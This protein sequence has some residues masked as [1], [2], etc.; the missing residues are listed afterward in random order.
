[1]FKI[2]NLKMCLLYF[3][4]LGLFLPACSYMESRNFYSAYKQSNCEEARK[5]LLNSLKKNFDQYAP[6]Y[7]LIHTYI[8]SGELN[9]AIKQINALLVDDGVDKFE[10]YFMKGYLLGETGD[11]ELALGAYQD[12]LDI[13]SDIKIKQNMELLLKG[14]KSGAK[15]KNKK[16]KGKKNDKSESD[17][18]GKGDDSDPERKNKNP[19]D[20]DQSNKDPKN[21]SAKKMTKQQIQKIMKEIDG[22]EKKIRSQGIKIKTKKGGASDGKNW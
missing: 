12:A 2:N 16:G 22:D 20:G 8:C 4:F 15:G 6:K 1:M 21:D 10:L 5:I 19:S 13:R 18:D 11:L 3:V 17:D 7:N 9:L 14:S